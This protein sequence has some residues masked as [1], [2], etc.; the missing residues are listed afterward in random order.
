MSTKQSIKKA[1]SKYY[2]PVKNYLQRSKNKKT[3]IEFKK[4]IWQT[5][6]ISKAFIKGSDS[7][8]VVAAEMMDKE[9]NEFFLAQCKPTDAVL[10]IGCGHG[11]VS[12]YLAEHG[13]PVTAADISEKLLEEFRTRIA[14]KNLPVEIVRADAYKQPFADNRFDVVVA[15]MFLPH[16]PDWPVVLREMTR[17]TKPGGKLLVHFCS[18]EN[19]AFGKKIGQHDCSFG[20][21]PDTINPWL[22]YADADDK[23]LKRVAAATGLQLVS[24]T[25]ISFFLGNRLFGYQL[26]TEAYNAYTKEME[27]FLKDE[28]VKEFVSWFDRNITT[29]F[30]PVMSYLNIITFVKK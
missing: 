10:D 15:R 2:H 3:I 27:G 28:R 29:Q 30:A 26:G 16:F 25:P 6:E 8:N 11:I 24:R 1:L 23:E 14:G 22:Y 18:A 13:I 9:V 7:G 4:D 20:T 17:V 12:E 19:V 21:T 5:D